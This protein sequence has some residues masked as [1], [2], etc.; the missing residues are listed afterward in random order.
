M[1]VVAGPKINGLRDLA[2]SIDMANVKSYAGSGTTINNQ[3][4]QTTNE[5]SVKAS[6]YDVYDIIVADYVIPNDPATA[7][8]TFNTTN[9]GTATFDGI[10]NYLSFTT[11]NLSSVVSVEIWARLGAA[12]SDN[13]M[14]GF[15]SYC[16]R[17]ISGGLGFT[18]LN[19]DLYG[20][21]QAN[22]TSLG[23][24]NAWKHYVF[25]MRTDVAYTNNKLYVDTVSQALTQQTG[26]ELAANRRLNTNYGAVGAWPNTQGY[27]MPMTFGLIRIYN[28]ALTQ[29]EITD[30]Y[31]LNRYRFI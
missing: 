29:T 23:L 1:A 16:I 7:L 11:P 26:S 24:V 2:L 28:R 14:I 19:N 10:G 6:F 22:V 15:D 18:T 21:S 17:S 20:I 13:M 25:E 30:N 4:A 31:N 9:F 8:P 27:E 3:M 12:Y 5:L